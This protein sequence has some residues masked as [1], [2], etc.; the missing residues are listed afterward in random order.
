MTNLHYIIGTALLGLPL[1][2]YGYSWHKDGGDN[3]GWRDTAFYRQ[4]F[5]APRWLVVV[6]GAPRPDNYLEIGAVALQIAGLFLFVAPL[7]MVLTGVR[8][9]TRILIT[10]LVPL[11]SLAIGLSARV[12]SAITR[13]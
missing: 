9:R 1:W 11:S 5:N 7:I 3:R 6:S 12:V 13:R 2:L 4:M 10:V 8:I